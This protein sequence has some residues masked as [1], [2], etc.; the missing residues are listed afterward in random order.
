MQPNIHHIQ[1]NGQHYY[2][3]VEQDLTAPC[4]AC[5]CAACGRE[6]Y[7][8]YI[9]E[10]KK[11]TL[12][13]DAAELEQLM[14]RFLVQNQSN[15][16]ELPDFIRAWNEDRDWVVF[17]S[18]EGAELNLADLKRAIELLEP[19]IESPEDKQLWQALF[20]YAEKA[21]PLWILHS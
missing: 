3:H 4:P 10:E 6:G 16:A 12:V 17:S 9:D 15:Y 2:F 1:S 7:L 11:I 18:Y 21:Q 20:A 13:Y 14:S 5:G 19:V 8:W